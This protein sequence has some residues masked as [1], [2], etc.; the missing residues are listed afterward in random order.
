MS[1]NQYRKKPVV[2]EAVLWDGA[3]INDVLA[4]VDADHRWKVGV[5]DGDVDGPGIGHTPALGTLDIPTLEG[6]MTAQAVRR[7]L[8]QGNPARIP[9][10]PSPRAACMWVGWVRR[11]TCGCIRHPHP[12]GK[13]RLRSARR[14]GV[15][16]PR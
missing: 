13:P 6:V 1:S 16:T 2:I 12:K 11:R 9:A 5:D 14:V 10:H 8:A 7:A 15:T 3:H 4:F